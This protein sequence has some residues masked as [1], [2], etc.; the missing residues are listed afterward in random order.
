MTGGRHQAIAAAALVLKL[1]VWCLIGLSAIVLLLF[2]FQVAPLVM[3]PFYTSAPDASSRRPSSGPGTIEP[4]LSAAQIQK[5]VAAMRELTAS[6]Q[7]V[8]NAATSLTIVGLRFNRLRDERLKVTGGDG[9]SDPLAAPYPVKLDLSQTNGDALLALSDKGIEWTI[10]PPRPGSPRAIFGIE[11]HVFPEF[12]HPPKGV[13]AGFRTSDTTH[14]SIA[15]PLLA[16]EATEEETR[17]FCQSV[18]DWAGFFSLPI[19]KVRYVLMED[20]TVLQ[21]GPGG[22]ISQGRIVL[23]LENGALRN[24]CGK[25]DKDAWQ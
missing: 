7:A 3:L 6:P 17:K 22:W 21:F 14:R 19:S 20:P 1:G 13:L 15:T 12:N 9:A 8:A 5:R 11:S 10:V 23:D 18:S 2:L 16:H 24:R 4:G 25:F